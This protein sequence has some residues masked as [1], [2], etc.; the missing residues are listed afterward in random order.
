MV[1]LPSPG[2][3]MKVLVPWLPIRVSLPVPPTSVSFS[4]LAGVGRFEVCGVDDVVAAERVDR[5]L[6]VGPSAPVML[7]KGKGLIVAAMG[8][9]KGRSGRHH[10]LV[11]LMMTESV[12][13]SP[14]PGGAERGRG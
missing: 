2:F 1:S 8:V 6:V 4:E 11:P 9:S 3:Q 5:E 14:T 13:P 7:T 10:R 12:S